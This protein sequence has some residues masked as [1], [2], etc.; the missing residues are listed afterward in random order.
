M[1]LPDTWSGFKEKLKE[2]EKGDS[3]VHA[4]GKRCSPSGD[5]AAHR[6]HA[7][8]ESEV[9]DVMD[10]VETLRLCFKRLCVPRTRPKSDKDDTGTTASKTQGTLTLCEGLPSMRS[11]G[12]VSCHRH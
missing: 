12:F 10:I 1:I 6:G 3:S 5:A 4:I 8:T 2:L 11:S 7:A 9:Q